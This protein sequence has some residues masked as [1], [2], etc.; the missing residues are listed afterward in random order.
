MREGLAAQ[1]IPICRRKIA[2][3]RLLARDVQI[4][5][6]LFGAVDNDRATSL[7]EAAHQLLVEEAWV[8]LE[9]EVTIPNRP[10]PIRLSSLSDDFETTEATMP[11]VPIEVF[12]K[13][14]ASVRH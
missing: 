6:G 3:A 2:R 9:E 10:H 14:L 5:A 8:D 7:L 11:G 4:V 13:Y 12:R 1:G